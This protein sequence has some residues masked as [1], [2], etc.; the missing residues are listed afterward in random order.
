ML[1]LTGKNGVNGH[2][3]QIWVVKLELENV[4]EFIVWTMDKEMGCYQMEQK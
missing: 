3:V 2:H 4:L 1:G